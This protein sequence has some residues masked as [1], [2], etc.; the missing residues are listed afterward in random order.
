[1]GSNTTTTRKDETMT[2]KVRDQNGNILSKSV[3]RDA[4]GT[5]SANVWFGSPVATNVR[6]YYGYKTRKAAQESCISDTPPLRKPMEHRS[7]LCTMHNVIEPGD[8]IAIYDGNKP[9]DVDY[10]IAQQN[11]RQK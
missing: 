5:W 11:D 10:D 4:D 9:M 8:T 1:M 6:R 7:L 2:E 3:R